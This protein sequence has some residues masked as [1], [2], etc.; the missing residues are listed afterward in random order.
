MSGMN[1]S[2]ETVHLEEK[3]RRLLQY[4]LEEESIGRSTVEKIPARDPADSTPLS[5]AQQRLWLVNQIVDDDSAY[6]ISTAIHLQGQLDV[7]ALEDS[8]NELVRRHEVLR[9]TFAVV[10]G[11]PSQVISAKELLDLPAIDLSMLTQQAADGLA[12]R[13]TVEDALRPFSL[14]RWPLIR[15]ALVVPGRGEH[16]LT[17]SMHHIVS[18]GWSLGILKS[19]IAALYAAFSSGL[20]SALPELPIQYADF[21]VWSRGWLEGPAAAADLDYWKNRLQG[22]LPTI[23]MPTDQARPVVQTFQ[24]D[25]VTIVLP[26]TL[27][28]SQRALCRR[29]GATL[30]MVLLAAF[31]LLVYRY[32]GQHDLIVGTPIA[33]RNR[34]ELEPLIGFFLNTLVLRTDLSGNPSFREL[35]ARVRDVAL[36]AYSH[37]DIPFEML[38][39]ELKP[40]RDLGRPPLFQLMFNMLNVA[41]EAFSLPGLSIADIDL[42][43][44]K[45]KFDLTLYA[46]EQGEELRLTAV[47]STSVLHRDTVERM[48][49]H[50][51]TL[52]L[53]AS[54]DP[55]QPIQ[56]L[57]LENLDRLK[58]VSARSAMEAGSFRCV[59]SKPYAPQSI[60]DRF[61]AQVE[62]HP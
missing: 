46:A 23:E 33:N 30:F 3:K 42:Q 22:E 29:D 37:Q 57:A 14:D 10:D 1:N 32:T 53:N 5:F 34:Q 40:S 8:F 16:V 7:P 49:E 43:E 51:R 41:E 20:P 15:T 4:L 28:N 26:G 56:M 11:Q 39:E 48:L 59:E 44:T 52:L 2:L 6:N 35:L 54:R 38:V 31:K 58:P 36:G 13:L 27:A 12:E 21:A 61:T 62:K 24:G 45:S 47:Y 19:E 9:T 17:F 60:W 18:D 25:S 55:D 50:L